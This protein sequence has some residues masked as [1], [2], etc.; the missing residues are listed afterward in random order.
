MSKY[1]AVYSSTF[2]RYFSLLSLLL[3]IS[4]S[5][6]AG[7]DNI[8][9]QD[10]PREA[11]ATLLLIKRGG[12]FPFEKD[13]STFGNYERQLPKK[14]RGYYREYTVQKKNTKSRGAQRIVAGGNEGHLIEFY[15]TSDHYRSFQKIKE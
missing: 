6:C 10:L 11:Q 8:A 5:A 12:P 14:A 1:F 7:A 4:L 3:G 15:Y 9:Y 13:G 2:I